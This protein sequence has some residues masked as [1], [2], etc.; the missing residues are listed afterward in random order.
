MIAILV[1]GSRRNPPC[2][3]L[4]HL[5]QELAKAR[6]VIHGDAPGVDHAASAIARNLKVDTL[7]MPALWD[8]HGRRAGP[9]RNG[10]MVQVLTHLRACGWQTRVLA[11]PEADSK[12]TW[13]CVGQAE[14]AGFTVEVFPPEKT[15]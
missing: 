14:A 7:P 4:N 13:D 11:Y 15:K 10:H 9:I 5:S 2:R 6:L 3:V 12:G 1:T 8:E